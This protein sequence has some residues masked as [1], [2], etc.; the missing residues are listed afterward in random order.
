[1][2]GE[3]RDDWRRQRQ[4]EKTTTAGESTHGGRAGNGDKHPLFPEKTTTAVE[5]ESVSMGGGC[6]HIRR[7]RHQQGRRV[8]FHPLN[9]QS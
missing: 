2:T 6:S 4:S 5:D 7:W 3:D 8:R 1:M 9:I